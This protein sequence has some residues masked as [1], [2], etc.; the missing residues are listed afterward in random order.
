[1]VFCS[2]ACIAAKLTENIM[3][4][5]SQVLHIIF[6]PLRYMAKWL[7]KS[8]SPNW[9]DL[10]LIVGL[11]YCIYA[12]WNMS[13]RIDELS[14]TRDEEDIVS[15]PD[16]L[17]IPAPVILEPTKG[18]MVMNSRI[19]I[20]GEAEDNYIISL[21]VNGLL[22]HV[23]LPEKGKFYFKNIRLTRGQNTVEVRAMSK[24]GRVSTLQTIDIVYAPPHFDYLRQTVSRGPLDKKQISLTF[25]GG[26]YDNIADDILRILKSK[27]VKC[28]FFLTG[29]FIRS[30]PGTV[31]Q[32]VADGH[33]IGNHTWSHPKLT[34]FEENGRHETREN[35]TE[36]QVADELVKTASLFHLVTGQDM[37]DL[38]RAPYGY[39]NRD[40]LDWAAGAGYKHIG[41]TVGRGW[42]ETMD[43][44][45][46]V[47]DKSSEVY[48][49]S[50]EIAEKILNY[51]KNKR[52]GSNGLILLMHL[53][54]ER[55]DDFPHEKLPEIID[56]L[57]KQGY[58]LVPVSQLLES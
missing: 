28:T 40:I 48:Y 24:E 6:S 18:G 57:R 43:T 58:E 14:Q 37:K 42:E 34:T 55:D 30:H 5:I 49:T 51:G 25:D 9:L 26:S 53:G 27:Q 36:R 41:W 45:D 35:V 11:G 23:V 29:M 31:R 19:D 4:W 44:L 52:H 38:W 21:A 22:K 8:P 47:A 13:A 17:Q 46:W 2:G 20:A 33:E 12:L 16:S 15:M 3:K 32:I 54:S 39:Y 56:G 50:E 10:L 1:M 7:K